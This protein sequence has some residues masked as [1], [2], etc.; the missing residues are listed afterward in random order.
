M[1]DVRIS[2]FIIFLVAFIFLPACGGGSNESSGKTTS[3]TQSHASITTST[4]IAIR[5][6]AIKGPI[7]NA[8]LALYALNTTQP[9]FYDT[10]TPLATG[11][12]NPHAA[13]EGLTLARGNRGPFVLIVDAAN[14]T[15]LNT[16]TFPAIETLFQIVTHDMLDAGQPVYITPLTTLAFYMARLQ[17]PGNAASDEFLAAMVDASEKVETALNMQLRDEI[18][19]LSDPP[20]NAAT[21][22]LHIT[23]KH[24]TAHRLA[25]EKA[26]AIVHELVA[27]H[28][29]KSPTH[30]ALALARDIH[31]DGVMD[32]SAAGV[33]IE[34]LDKE[35]LAK[36]DDELTI[37][38]TTYPVAEV[39]KVLVT[40]RS[41]MDVMSQYLISSPFFSASTQTIFKA[42]RAR[43]P[44]VCANCDRVL[45]LTWD[46]SPSIVSGYIIYFKTKSH[47]RYKYMRKLI[48]AKGQVNPAAPSYNFK[49]NTLGLITG[50]TLCFRV[51]AYNN[52]G[53]SPLSRAICTPVG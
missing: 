37:P 42:T 29:E 15:D 46:P 41:L 45:K 48:I 16:G 44:L 18:D 35:I 36:K 38:N 51:K 17:T 1:P 40:E 2:F 26:A 47:A 7:A 24:V 33:P 23:A 49:A 39:D 6:A 43:Q 10:Q 11:F 3:P 52:A 50:D 4:D 13:I 8:T 12:T 27:A 34:G 31:A 25:I 9:T 22:P 28:P 53:S 5:G 21:N 14:A 19:I 30:F 32:G 20:I